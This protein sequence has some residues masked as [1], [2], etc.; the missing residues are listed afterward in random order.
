MTTL[1]IIVGTCDVGNQTSRQPGGEADAKAGS[2]GA[3]RLTG[4]LCEPQEMYYGIDACHDCFAEISQCPISG[5][6]GEYPAHLHSVLGP[7][8][9]GCHVNMPWAF[10]DVSHC[11]VVQFK[12]SPFEITRLFTL[13]QCYHA[14]VSYYPSHRF[15]GLASSLFFAVIIKYSIFECMLSGLLGTQLI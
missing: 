2:R 14:R 1:G 9:S 6:S 3:T 15:S 8:P 12:R 5:G 11:P 10:L 7:W 4:R 13:C